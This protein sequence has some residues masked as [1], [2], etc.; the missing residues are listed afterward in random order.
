MMYDDKYQA[1]KA[2]AKKALAAYGLTREDISDTLIFAECNSPRPVN[3]TDCPV[4]TAYLGN[5]VY[6]FSNGSCESQEVQ[7]QR[8][9][10][11]VAD[12]LAYGEMLGGQ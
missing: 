9:A 1:S 12:S 10:D 6:E 11:S 7:Y 4:A 8:V 5:G 3:P 2:Q